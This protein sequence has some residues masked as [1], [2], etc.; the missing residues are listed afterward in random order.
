MP[1]HL[2]LIPNQWL[3]LTMQG[4]GSMTVADEA[5]VMLCR[6]FRSTADGLSA[7]HRDG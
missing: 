3:H 4:I 2:T 5:I 6:V 7:L 1:E